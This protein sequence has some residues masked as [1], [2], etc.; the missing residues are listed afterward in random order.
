MDKNECQ[1][2]NI[3]EN[4]YHLAKAKGLKI[5]DLEKQVNASAGYLSRFRGE[6]V[7]SAPKLEYV[8]GIANILGVTVDNLINVDYLSIT[9]DEKYLLDV[10]DRLIDKTNRDEQLWKVETTQDIDTIIHRDCNSLLDNIEPHPLCKA[11]YKRNSDDYSIEEVCWKYIPPT[12]DYDTAEI[13][14]DCYH[15]VLNP[16]VHGE[17]TMYIVKSKVY[18]V[19]DTLF[20]DDSSIESYDLYLAIDH[21][22]KLVC[23]TLRLRKFLKYKLIELYEAVQASMDRTHVDESVRNVLDAYMDFTDIPF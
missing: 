4:V 11:N 9:K 20:D 14:G 15:T 18:N 5:G 16:H 2:K 7:T 6:D 21:Q 22:R 23:T 10:L 8:V 3:I 19:A 17:A 1:W 13:I 12:E